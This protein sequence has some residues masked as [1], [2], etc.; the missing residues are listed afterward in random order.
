VHWRIKGWESDPEGQLG[1]TSRRQRMKCA[2]LRARSVT[3]QHRTLYHGRSPEARP[4]CLRLRASVPVKVRRGVYVPIWARRARSRPV[5]SIARSVCGVRA[6]AM[7]CD[8][9]GL[10]FT[11]V[12]AGG[13]VVEESDL[14]VPA[15]R[16]KRGEQLSWL[17]EETEALLSR[18]RPDVVYVKKAGAGKFAAA[19]ERHEV[20]GVVQVAAHRKGVP[21]DLRSTEQIRSSHVPKAKGAYEGLLKLPDVAARSNAAKRERY[22]Y[23]ITALKDRG[24]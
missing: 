13:H 24:A 20:E 22:L 1:A 18:A 19:P 11:V 16:G 7:I 3:G 17:L 6:L 15:S 8:R 12:D 5:R 10:S 9:N 23:A 21:C 4:G 14:E 2:D